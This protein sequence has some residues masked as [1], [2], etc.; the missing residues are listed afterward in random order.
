MRLTNSTPRTPLPI[1]VVLIGA[2]TTLAV[3][4]VAAMVVTSVLLP[5]NPAL[6]ERIIVY[7]GGITAGLMLLLRSAQN[8]IGL[9]QVHVDLNS[10]LTAFMAAQ[11]EQERAKGVLEGTA[12][13][14]QGQQDA[15]VATAVEAARVARQAAE[16]ATA[17]ASA[18]A[19]VAADA[20]AALAAAHE[21]ANQ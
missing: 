16:T 8:A 12:L 2:I 19:Q 20:A 18:V 5:D 3:V 4:T 14:A 7:V 11:A 9:Y 21:R 6:A 10:R 13:S 1:S 15:I 17:A